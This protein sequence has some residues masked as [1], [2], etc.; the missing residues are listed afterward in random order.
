[1]W[2]ASKICPPAANGDYPDTA[3]SSRSVRASSGPAEPQAQADRQPARPR[4]EHDQRATTNGVTA[5]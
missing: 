1:M 2:A 3:I 4:L 5:N